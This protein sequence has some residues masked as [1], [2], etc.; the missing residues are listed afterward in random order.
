MLRRL[1]MALVAVL[2]FAPSLVAQTVPTPREHLGFDIG[3]DRTLANW[4]ELTSYYE[5]LANTSE[6]VLLDTLGLATAG[7]PF[8][9]LTIT[10]PENH[11]RLDELHD[12]QMRLAD[13]RLVQTEAELEQLLTD[14]KTVVLITQGIHATEVGASQ[15]SA[16]LA[17][18]LAASQDPK[19]L[20][21]LDEVI[22][23]QIPSLNPDGLQWVA[24]WYN[25]NVGTEF[26]AAPLPWLYHFYTGHDNN[27][28]WYAFTQKETALTVEFAHNAWHPQ[29]VH[30]VHQMGGYGARIFVPPYID[31]WEPNVDPALV[32][33]VSQ[34]GSYMA[35]ELTSQGK[36][37]VVFSG[38][39]DAFTPARAYM[40][41]HGGARVLSETASANLA[42]P[43][44]VPESRLGPGRNYDAGQRSWNFPD[45]W[46][47]GVWRLAD[48]VE[49]Q[50]AGALALLTN[51]ARNR[52]YWLENF[53]GINRRAVE[54]WDAWPDAWIIPAGQ[55]N[56]PG[57][58]YAL[59][60]LTMGDVEVHQASSDFTIDDLEFSAGS[61]VIPMNQPYASFANTLLEVQQY[62]DLREY[63]GGPPRRPYDVTAHTLGY[64]MDFE[65]VAVDGTLEMSLTP[66]ISVS[67]FDFR[68]P[69][70]LQGTD[71]PRIAMYKS[72]QEP[73]T[74]GWQRWVFD[75]HGLPYDTLHDADI[76]DGRLADYDV[77]IF[78]AQGARSIVDGF[79]SDQVPAEYAGGLGDR[80][81][82]AVRSFVQRGGRVIAVEAATE[83]VAELLN[84]G[85]SDETSD[86]ANTEFYIPGS[87]LRV[88]LA[89]GSD[90]VEGLDREVAAWFWGSSR[91]FAVDDERVNVLA[92][93]GSGDPLL[94]GWALGGEL[95]AGTPAILEAYVGE[96]SVVLFGFQPNYRAQT[97]GTWPLLFNA[98]RR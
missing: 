87:I 59:R 86:Y 76:R 45:P 93:Y 47:G 3:A 46:E 70:H 32:T 51:A 61:Y 43:L 41:Y 96:G 52:R 49:Y 16:N 57:I 1:M 54:K 67:D 75:Q 50:K 69:D 13:P 23:L 9:M 24:D 98:I 27:R 55:D 68:L 74:A 6:R 26:E 7:S 65:A 53:Y 66:P 4:D 36:Q 39:Y 15:M 85:V 78:Q 11:A 63:P 71:V 17:Y 38:I 64:L 83:F 21:I 34:L 82:G 92:R 88:E 20:E 33:A 89:P 95:L 44:T 60:I 18:E 25:E 90:V 72:W 58:T 12:I 5:A 91:A 94:S 42:S 56:D 79:R 29:I 40:H 10:S 97:L 62:P 84:L 73:M 37:G 30:D 2:S 14:G 22:I 81:S 31:P 80:G 77:L 19:I 48:I 35:A 28:D 8:V